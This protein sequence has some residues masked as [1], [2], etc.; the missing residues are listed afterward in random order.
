MT[1]VEGDSSAAEQTSAGSKAV[2][3]LADRTTTSATPFSRARAAMA[4]SIAD[5]RAEVAT[6]SLPSCR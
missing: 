3:S 6:T 5:S 1:P 2:A 4:S